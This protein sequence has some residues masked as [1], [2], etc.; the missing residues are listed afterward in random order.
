MF[1]INNKWKDVL[2]KCSVTCAFRRGWNTT[3]K[4]QQLMSQDIRKTKNKQMF[5]CQNTV[6]HNLNIPSLRQIFLSTFY[7]MQTKTWHK[8]RLNSVTV[9]SLSAACMRALS[10]Y[11]IVQSVS[12]KAKFWNYPTLIFLIQFVFFPMGQRAHCV[13]ML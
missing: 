12:L 7:F 9:S 11:N 2:T 6:Y 5:S 8:I 4:D 10:K 13:R 1:A 3:F